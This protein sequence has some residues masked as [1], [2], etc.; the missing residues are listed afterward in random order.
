MY[1]VSNPIHETRLQDL[2]TAD[3]PQF[4]RTKTTESGTARLVVACGSHLVVN[5]AQ[6]PSMDQCAHSS[7]DARCVRSQR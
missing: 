3:H 4:N 5:S 6:A 7:A 2:R 1:F